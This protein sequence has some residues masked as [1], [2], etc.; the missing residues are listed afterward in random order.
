[1]IH[2]VDE[3]LRQLLLGEMSRI[4]GNVIASAEQVTF[5][6]PT[7]LEQH[8]PKRPGIN[9]YLHDVREATRLREHERVLAER[10]ANDET[11]ARRR[12]PIRLDLAYLITVHAGDEPSAEHRLLTDVLGVF[13]R[14]A[15]LPA[16][17]LTEK[18]QEEAD[19]G[20]LLSIAQPDQ[21]AHR[22][23]ARLWQALG[24]RLRPTL[25]LIATASFNPFE[26]SVTRIVKE[27]V[28]ALGVGVPP[29]GPNR[30]LTVST[31]RVSAAG[32]VCDQ[33]GKTLAGV[34]VEA[35]G[36][37]KTVRT[38]EKGFFHFL[39]LPARRITLTFR[40][41]GYKTLE[42]PT[43]VPPAGR[44]DL[45]EPLGVTL[46]ALGDAERVKELREAALGEGQL[47]DLGRKQL[48]TVSGRLAYPSGKPAA[49]IMVRA[50]DKETTTDGDGLYVFNNLREPVKT[51]TAFVPGVGE[52]SVT[53]A[54]ATTTLVPRELSEEKPK[55]KR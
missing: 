16:R 9:L 38:D 34:A 30:P 35:K 54:E 10:N 49:F 25:G 18:M 1:M 45:L 8:P 31:T 19:N 12:A 13:L 6:P 23:P 40:L 46:T 21:E 51:V 3:S 26:T 4:E 20:V 32:V 53:P 14:S 37:E 44:P 33:E 5:L 47:L 55:A 17:Y 22:D 48:I 42:V 50:G 2:E 29:N 36:F 7:T 43:N 52:V 41:S 15:V 11:V 28:L 39:N 27:A 24:G